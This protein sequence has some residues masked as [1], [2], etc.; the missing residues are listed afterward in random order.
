MY[1]DFNNFLNEGYIHHWND[2]FVS[3]ITKSIDQNIEYDRDRYE[4]VEEAVVTLEWKLAFEVFDDGIYDFSA[5]GV[6]AI[7]TIKYLLNEHPDPE[8][9]KSQKGMD[10][11]GMDYDYNEEDYE[12]VK[13]Y[14]ISAENIEWEKQGI[15]KQYVIAEVDVDVTDDVPKLKF[16]FNYAYI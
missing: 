2:T 8:V 13:T 15:V 9:A 4:S 3:K 12:E 6:K 1:K 14:E 16:R 11:Y 5:T 7:V 10:K